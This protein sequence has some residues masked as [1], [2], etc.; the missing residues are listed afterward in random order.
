[1]MAATSFAVFDD[2]DDVGHDEVAVVVRSWRHDTAAILRTTLA[3]HEL[4]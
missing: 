3:I 4:A 1:M 2:I